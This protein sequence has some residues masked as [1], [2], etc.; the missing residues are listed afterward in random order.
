MMAKTQTITTT[1]EDYLEAIAWLVGDKGVARVRDI[2]AALSVH[3]STV[4]ATLRS[5]AEKGFVHYSA[6]E[7]ATLTPEGRKIAED[8]IRR[9]EIVREFFIE[10]LA[11]DREMADANACRI[12]HV[13]DAE[14]L[15]RLASFARFVK[16]CPSAR[17]QCLKQFQAAFQENKEAALRHDATQEDAPASDESSCC[18]SRKPRKPAKKPRE[19]KP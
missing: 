12:E 1:L 8:V 7:A 11:L 4:T 9:H 18:T 16:E 15:D 3:K 5:L 19:P 14:V 6:Y 2:S 17:Q 10:V 13:M